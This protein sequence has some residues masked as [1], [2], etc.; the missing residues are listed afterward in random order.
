VNRQGVCDAG[1]VDT[2]NTENND[3]ER[4]AVEHACGALGRYL[5]TVFRVEE[6][7]PDRRARDREAIDFTATN[8]GGQVLGI[9]HTLVE[10]YEGQIADMN[11][12]EE[13]L[14]EAR[15]RLEGHL[16]EDSIF[17]IAFRAGSASRIRS[18]EAPAVA[19]W[20]EEVA[21]S[22]SIGRPGHSGHAI[23]SPEGRF[24]VALTVRR[25][26]RQL[27]GPQVRYRID[28]DT[29]R[30]E[31]NARPRVEKAL[32]KKL[33]KLEASRSDLGARWTMLCLETDDWQMTNPWILGGLLRGASNEAPLPDHIVLV[34]DAPGAG[35][36]MTWLIRVSR[37]WLASPSFHTIASTSVQP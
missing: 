10:P 8:P 32:A 5:D 20:I 24:A 4:L 18:R 22:L 2:V 21:P 36:S 35:P 19:E 29:E 25:W 17:D 15:R 12:A 11:T 28:V 6:E 3:S 34:M 13:R 1:L 26:P 7:R 27:P 9:E 23:T 31:D 37:E 30:N 33:P 16:P 14:G